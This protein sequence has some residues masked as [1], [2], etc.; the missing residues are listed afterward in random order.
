MAAA[1]QKPGV[2]VR[3]EGDVAAALAGAPKKLESVYEV[4]FLVHAAMEPINCTVHVRPD[5]CEVWTGS[6]VLSRAQAVAAKTAGLPLSKV[7]VHNHYLGGGF[8]RRLEGDFVPQAVRIAQKVH[9]PVKVIW[10][11]AEDIQHD[12]YRPYYY[13]RL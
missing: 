7:G 8:G 2:I 6:Q 11:R 10:T 1:A 4:P 5:R 9:G 12:V 3:N 13:D